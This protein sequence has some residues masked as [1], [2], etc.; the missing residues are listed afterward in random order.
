MRHQLRVVGAFAMKDFRVAWSYRFGFIMSHVTPIY[1]VLMFYFISRVVGVS[2]VVGGPDE[3]FRFVVVGLVL[4]DILRLAAEAAAGA[5]RRDQI[6]GT[7]ENLMAEPLHLVTIGL[8]WVAFPLADSIL[9]GGV[10]LLLA[11]PLGFDMGGVNPAALAL[12]LV[13]SSLVFMGFG[14]VGAAL[15]VAFQ[16]GA[17]LIGIFLAVLAILSGALFPVSVL[18][19]PLELL[20][21]AS[22]MLYA[23]D[24][25]RGA[26]LDGQ[27]ISAISTDLLV[28]AITALVIVPLSAY[29][30]AVASR[31]A[32]ARG[33]LS[34]F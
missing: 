11:W 3:Y 4:G 6:E 21:Q 23:L 15:V 13:L 18:P 25:T 28:L 8:G 30:L 29:A 2:P 12:A 5:A 19:K 1:A 17:G 26:A 31:F 27:S 33:R 34:A 24:S 14:L 22:P 20:S 32:R 16:Q 10:T 9:R 7:L